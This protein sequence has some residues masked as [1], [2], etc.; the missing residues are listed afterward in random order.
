TVCCSATS[1]RSGCGRQR[2][3]RSRYASAQARIISSVSGGRAWISCIMVAEDRVRVSSPAFVNPLAWGAL[4][5][6]FSPGLP[7]GT[8]SR[9]S[10]VASELVYTPEELLALP[11]HG[12]GFELV[13]GR[14]VE[15][16]K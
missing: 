1:R 13:R 9:M 11:D 15:K 4:P 10:A 5:P 8:D 2:P 16:K 12:K 14:L 6:G 3:W 7:P